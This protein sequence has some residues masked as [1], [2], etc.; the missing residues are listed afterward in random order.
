M[1]GGDIERWVED[2]GLTWCVDR[3]GWR[4]GEGRT[5]SMPQDGSELIRNGGVATTMQLQI[6]WR[7]AICE[8]MRLVCLA[9]VQARG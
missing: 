6:S 5:P 4:C 1:L 7:A 9:C 8:T 3:W 2:Q